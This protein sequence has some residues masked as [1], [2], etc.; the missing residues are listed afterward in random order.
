LPGRDDRGG[1]EVGGNDGGTADDPTVPSSGTTEFESAP[2][3]TASEAIVPERPPRS[4][5]QL[6]DAVFSFA[7]D[8]ICEWVSTDEVADMVSAVYPWDGDA[9]IKESVSDDEA[10][11]AGCLWALTG[12]DGNGYLQTG[13]AS[14]WVRIGGAPLEVSEE[15][16]VEYRDAE[17]VE[18]GIAVSG[19]PG[20]SDGV[21]VYNGAFGQFAFWVPPLDEYLAFSMMVPEVGGVFDEDRFFLVAD[22]LLRELGWIPE[23]TVATETDVD[24]E[25]SMAEPHEPAQD[26]EASSG[27]ESGAEGEPD[28]ADTPSALAVS[29]DGVVYVANS[30]RIARRDGS[31]QWDSIDLGALPTGRS[32]V[33]AESMPG[34]SIENLA[35]APDGTLWAAGSAYSDVDDVEFGGVA[36]GWFDV[37]R[38][39]WIAAYDCDPAACRWEV[40]TS[41]DEPVLVRTAGLHEWPVSAGD[42]EVADDGSVYAPVDGPALL[43]ID[44]DTWTAHQRVGFESNVYPWSGSIAITDDGTVWAGLFHPG[45]DLAGEG[46]GLISFDGASFTHH[47]TDT[48]LPSNSVFQ[49]AA[50]PDGSLWA[51]TDT[52]YSNPETARPDAADGVFHFDGT[53]WTSFTMDDGLLSNDAVVVVGADNTVWAL[54]YEIPPY[55]YSSYADGIWTSHPTDP[56]GFGF[57]AVMAPDGTLWSIDWSN[58]ELINFDGATTVVHTPPFGTEAEGL[59]TADN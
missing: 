47:T 4:T 18:I 1:G 19:H 13:D 53:E 25:E 35:V 32:I 28:R 49:V 56:V 17:P 23:S 52:F 46:L 7:R 6:D 48:G 5:A 22:A 54:H 42:L 20:L 36:D 57:G 9:E 29:S 44:G 51:A 50:A 10:W 34:R 27:V 43:Q 41:N 16:G 31:G 58:G 2:P 59:S 11:P 45:E 14:M 24:A 26:I 38:L 55:G 37:R 39:S 30:T 12:G 21:V 15:P 40:A 3:V 8:E 33:G